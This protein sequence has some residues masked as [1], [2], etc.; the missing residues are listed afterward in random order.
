MGKKGKARRSVQR[1]RVAGWI[2]EKD[3]Q[4]D[5]SRSRVRIT[6][7]E[8]QLHDDA[9]TQFMQVIIVSAS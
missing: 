2:E 6:I 5:N 7:Q 9:A 4:K 1:W 8:G 3:I